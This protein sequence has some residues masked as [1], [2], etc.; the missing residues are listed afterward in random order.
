M[1]FHQ[2]STQPK[3]LTLLNKISLILWI[4]IS[5]ALL[6]FFTFSLFV[7]ALTAGAVIFALNFFRRGPS[8]QFPHEGNGSIYQSRVY[9]PTNP[10]DDDIIDV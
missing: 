9:K 10:R 5:L 1:I 2:F 8:S 7:I 6:S 4:V 3:K